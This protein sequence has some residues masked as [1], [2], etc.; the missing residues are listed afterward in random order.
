MKNFIKDRQELIAVTAIVLG[1]IACAI[2]A[3]LAV[4]PFIVR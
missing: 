3:G 1:F 4:H 2:V